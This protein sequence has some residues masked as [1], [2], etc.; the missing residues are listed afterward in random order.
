MKLRQWLTAQRTLPILACFFVY[1][2]ILH[3]VRPGGF[4]AIVPPWVPAASVMVAVSGAAEIVGGIGVVFATT[5][6]LA[7]IW[8]VLLLIAIFP[9]NVFML[10]HAIEEHSATWWLA[11]LWLRLPFQPLMIWWIWRGAIRPGTPA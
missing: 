5:R 3:F 1:A 7:G 2:G 8:L 4:V 10:H 11:L 6:Y 9:A